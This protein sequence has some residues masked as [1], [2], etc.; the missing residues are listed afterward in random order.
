[1]LHLITITFLFSWALFADVDDCTK[2]TSPDK[3][4]IKIYYSKLDDKDRDY[5]N[6]CKVKVSDLRPTQFAVG[7][8]QVKVKAEKLT[9]KKNEGKLR[10]YLKHRPEPIIVGPDG[11]FYIT[12][13]HHLARAL[14][15]IKKRETYGIILENHY[16]SGE[17]MVQFWKYMTDSNLVYL[18]DENGDPKSIR[19]LKKIKTVDA[20]KDDPYRSLAGEAKCSDDDCPT[21]GSKGFI[22]TGVPFEEF[23][24]AEHFR[25]MPE[26][27]NLKNKNMKKATLIALREVR[28]LKGRLP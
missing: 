5:T 7:Y 6:L 19:D 9:E 21:D 16:G 14:L 11:K 2:N 10:D 8:Y 18:I 20:L 25:K 13:H 3:N 24:W 23:K 17:E 12:D 27:Q 1:M 22:K 15:E 4:D 26:L 28:R